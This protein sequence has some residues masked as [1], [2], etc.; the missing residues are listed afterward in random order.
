MRWKLPLSAVLAVA[1]A[2][3]QFKTINPT[4]KEIVDAV[5]QERIAAIMK[6]LE[7]FETRNLFSEDDNPRRGIGAARRWIFD[8]FTS[9]SP[10]LEVRFDSYK[11]KKKGR[12]VRDVEIHNVVAVLPGKLNPERQ[13]ILSGHYDSLALLRPLQSNPDGSGQPAP[14]SQFDLSNLA[15][16]APG[17]SDDGSGTAAVLEL[18]RV[19][20]RYEFEKTIVFV[21]FTGEEEGLVGSTLY[22]RKARQENQ[23]IDGVLN[24]DIIGTEVSGNGRI[25]NGS[26]WVFSEEPDDSSSRELARYVQDMGERYLPS[27]R[28][29]LIFRPDRLGRGGDHTAFNLEGY[30]GVRFTTPNETYANQHTVTDTFANA[31]PAYATRVVQANAAALASLALAPKAPVTS[32]PIKSGPR[33]GQPTPMLGRGKSRYDAALRWKNDNPEPDLLGY[34][35]VMRKTTSPYWEREIF[36]GNVTEF[37][38]KDVSIDDVIFG[39]KAVDRNG[40]ESLVSPYVPSPRRK[41]EIETY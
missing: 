16:T 24:N 41:N 25:D 18:A 23:I 39:V 38:L 21:A 13:F 27:F 30:P 20:S 37:T 3:A 6:K 5:S 4:V 14:D 17:V 10:R 11:V 8:Q 31:S 29:D 7:S 1:S 40:N 32:E 19:M 2:S 15:P 12:I 34:V 9:Y 26:V 22:A 36:V 28:V 33:K 35:V